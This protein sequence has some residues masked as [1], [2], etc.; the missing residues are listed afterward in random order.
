[1]TAAMTRRAP[2]VKETTKSWSLSQISVPR[3][4]TFNSRAYMESNDQF[5]YY[6]HKNAGDGQ[7]V[8]VVEADGI[9][10]TQHTVRNMR[11][12]L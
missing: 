5:Y 2:A 10:W 1:M 12:Q 4:V 8:Y 6:Y 7:H 11:P 3:R 9:P